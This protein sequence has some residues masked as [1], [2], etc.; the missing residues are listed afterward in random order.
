MC[1]QASNGIPRNVL[2]SQLSEDYNFSEEEFEKEVVSFANGR[3]TMSLPRDFN[4]KSIRISP[5][6]RTKTDRISRLSGSSLKERMR[7]HR[8]SSVVS[9]EGELWAQQYSKMITDDTLEHINHT[10]NV[11]DAIIQKSGHINEEL[12]CHEHMLCTAEN[13]MSAVEHDTELTSKI[14]KEMSSLPGKIVSKMS[15]KKPKQKRKVLGKINIDSLNGHSGLLAFGGMASC[16]SLHIRAA[17]ESSKSHPEEQIKTALGRLG[18]ALDVI[19]AQQL[20]TAWALERQQ[21]HLNLF[22]DKLDKTTEEIS[23]QNTL[24]RY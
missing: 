3:R 17:S 7:E 16:E 6:K 24:M 14:L 2:S 15:R 21:G 10:L 22:G 18:N 5:L 23:R 11:A 13:D 20:D 12:G 4:G 1:S 9:Q 8:R 19:K